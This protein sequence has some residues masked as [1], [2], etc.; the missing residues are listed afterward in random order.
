MMLV[1]EDEDEETVKLKGAPTLTFEGGDDRRPKMPR[2]ATS[3]ENARENVHAKASR[4]KRG[5]RVLENAQ[6]TRFRV[7]FTRATSKSMMFKKTMNIKR[8]T[9]NLSTHLHHR[10]TFRFT[11]VRIRSHRRSR[12]PGEYIFARCKLTH[13]LCIYGLLL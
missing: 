1:E 7:E 10:R 4:Q 8:E 6:F 2:H 13:I 11:R 5:S 12:D 3:R 9:N